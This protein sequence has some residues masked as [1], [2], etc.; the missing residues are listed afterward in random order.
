MKKILVWYRNDLRL[1]DHLPLYQATQ[2]AQQVFLVYCID[3]RW[4]EKTFLDFKKTDYFRAKFLFESLCDLRMSARKLGGD[5]IVRIGIPEEEIAQ[6]AQYLGVQ[7]VFASQEVTYEE[8]NIEKKLEQTLQKKNIS[9]ELFWNYT[10]FHL[11]DLPFPVQKLPDVFTDFRKAVEKN[12]SVRKVLPP[13]KSL[14]PLPD[15]CIV[16]E[17]PKPKDVGLEE[18]PVSS[19]SVLLFKGGETNA[20]QR[21]KEYFWESDSLRH[22]KETRNELLGANYSSKFSAWLSLGCI[23]PRRIYSEVKRY[24]EERCK[25]DSTY[26]LIFE[27]M[28]RDYFRFV[29]KKY[30]NRIFMEKGIRNEDL[31]LKNNR[32][33]FEKWANGQTGI[34]FID[35]NMTELNETGFMSNRGRQNVV[36]FLVKDLK[37][38]WVWGAMYFESKLIDYDVCSNWGNWMYV[39][40]VGNDPRENRY[41]NILSQAK[42]YDRQGKYVK[43]WLPI[44]ESLSHHQVHQIG[45]LPPSELK[46]CQIELGLDYPRPLV[47]LARWKNSSP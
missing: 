24:E 42:R 17:I 8:I 45:D 10:L 46:N 6:V 39:A 12:T 21:L 27:L 30:G 4:F 43:F 26:W 13:P 41:F 38:N 19:K 5:L 34:P 36:S 40:G 23:S 32:K 20:L 28:W 14:N 47:D 44:L 7:A 2:K 9:L 35:A 22:Y 3:K 31:Q 37:I 15:D 1:H 16:G 29:A 11:D 25:N 33:L 18:H